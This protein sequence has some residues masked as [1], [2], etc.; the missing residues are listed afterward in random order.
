MSLST[1][2]TFT[3]GSAGNLISSESLVASGTV[4]ATFYIA[5]AGQ[6]G[7]Q[8]TTATGAAIYGRVQVW[9]TGGS[10]VSAT[11]GVLT[12]VF[13]TSDGTNYDTVPFGAQYIITTVASTPERQSFDLPPGQYKLTLTN[14]DGTYA[15]TVEATLGT[16]A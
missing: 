15:T 11:N 7:A 6:T 14:L 12:Q 10:S 8:G 9:N 13:A 3:T 1:A 5:V 4:S 16:A 2:P